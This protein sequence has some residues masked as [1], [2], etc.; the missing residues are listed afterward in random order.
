MA[1][2]TT[3][4]KLNESQSQLKSHDCRKGVFRAN[5]LLISMGRRK[6]TVVGRK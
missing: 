1:I 4:F 5:V 2:Q 6:E 3:L